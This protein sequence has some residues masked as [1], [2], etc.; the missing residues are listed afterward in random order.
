MVWLIIMDQGVRELIMFENYT[1]KS[2]SDIMMYFVNA[3]TSTL[4]Y[5]S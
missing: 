5:L 1:L 3:I 2:N 4:A